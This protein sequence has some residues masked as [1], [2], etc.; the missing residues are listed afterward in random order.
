MF[1]LQNPFGSPFASNHSLGGLGSKPNSAQKRKESS[2][3]SLSSA[4]SAGGEEKKD[5]GSGERGDGMANFG[6]KMDVGVDVDADERKT[7][8]FNGVEEKDSRSSPFGGSSST[9]PLSEA[10]NSASEAILDGPKIKRR[11][12]DQVSDTSSGSGSTPRDASQVHLTVGI[13]F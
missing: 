4:S 5:S 8:S 9:T 10:G 12:S 3:T 13:S 6:M 7:L 1:A 2:A 11:K